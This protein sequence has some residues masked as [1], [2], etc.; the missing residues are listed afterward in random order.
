VFLAAAGPSLDR[1]G[2]LLPAIRRR[3]VI[4]AVDTSLRFLLARGIDPD[5]AVVVDPQYWN[6]RHLDRAPAP[7]TCLVAE[8]A[9][10]P[11][12]LRHP[13]KARF[14]CGSLFPLGQFIEE[15]VDPKGKLGAGGSV[16]TTAWDFAR[17]LGAPSIWIAGLDLSFPELKTHFKGA[18]FETRSH[19]ESGRTL[20]AETWSVKALRD[21]QPF[22]AAASDG[23]R[24]L[25]DRRLSLYAAWFENRFAEFPQVRNYRLGSGS[26]RIAGLE[27]A[28]EAAL[29]ALP[30]RREEIDRLFAGCFSRV[31]ASF[32]EKEAVTKRAE[33]YEK[34]QKA[35]LEGLKRIQTIALDAA[36]AA[37]SAFIRGGG[38]AGET[39][40]K[41]DRA[42]RAI[43]ASEVKD[44][45]G[46][47]FP[48]IA[49]LEKTLTSPESNPFGRYLELSAALYRNL[50][51]A[52]EY[53]LSVLSV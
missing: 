47:L 6:A 3:C 46:F 45:A 31:E 53:N 21:G 1:I 8:S 48:P 13:F 26:L 28:E 7:K 44:V 39:L 12:V 20:P 36:G 9:V 24:V 23:G 17:V 32:A 40:E 11:P 15:R 27:T 22:L 50:A 4:V 5:F 14:L 2:R 52:A 30:D 18:L 42:N 51:K 37:E 35:L 10:Y 16:A 43:G 49:E 34:A 19:A 38:Q 41:L 29:L 25:T 33:R